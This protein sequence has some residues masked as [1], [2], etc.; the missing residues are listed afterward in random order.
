MPNI[1]SSVCNYILTESGEVSKVIRFLEI[2]YHDQQTFLGH[3][4]AIC[5]VTIFQLLVDKRSM[6]PILERVGIHAFLV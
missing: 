2:F 3:L 5:F 1:D 6:V 4:L